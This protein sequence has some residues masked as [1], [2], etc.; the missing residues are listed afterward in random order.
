VDAFS[1]ALTNPL[2]AER[3]FTAET[4]TQTGLDVI[5]ETTSLADLVARNVPVGAA[6]YT[7]TMRRPGWRRE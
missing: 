3:V 7:V 4:F 5:E 6:S 1:Q 2:L